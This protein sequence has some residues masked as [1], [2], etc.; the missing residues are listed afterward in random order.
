MTTTEKL[1]LAAGALVWLL[2]AL[3]IVWFDDAAPDQCFADVAR[4]TSR[5][6][7]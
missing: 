2:A 5:C 3:A 1:L 6:A 4:M 7:N